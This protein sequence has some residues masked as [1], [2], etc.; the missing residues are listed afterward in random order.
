[1][2]ILPRVDKTRAF[3]TA[4]WVLGRNEDR[5]MHGSA[6]AAL[7]LVGDRRAIPYIEKALVGAD[8]T[9]KRV[10]ERALAKLRNL[11]KD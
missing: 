8:D 3:K 1:L 7:E 4:L 6:M 11:N 10:A 2:R 5:A 9:L